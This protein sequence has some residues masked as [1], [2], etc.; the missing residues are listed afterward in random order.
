MHRFLELPAQLSCYEP[1]R[2][3]H[4]VSLSQ[5]ILDIDEQRDALGETEAC[6]LLRSFLSP[7]P[8]L[9]VDRAPTTSKNDQIT[10]RISLE[11]KY[12][13]F[14]QLNQVCI[15]EPTEHFAI[16]RG[17]EL[18]LKHICRKLQG[19]QPVTSVLLHIRCSVG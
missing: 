10:G 5:Q 14:S 1:G 19:K 8:L 4:V 16:L 6:T 7:R 2:S 12:H 18:G 9:A 15:E 3:K 11:A 17:L 13:L